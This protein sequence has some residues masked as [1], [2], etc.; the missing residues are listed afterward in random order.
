MKKEYK[1]IFNEI[2]PDDELLEGVFESAEKRINRHIPK[3]IIACTMCLAV[4]VAGCFAYNNFNS[5]SQ[6]DTTDNKTMNSNTFSNTIVAYASDD[7]PP[8]LLKADVETKL[9]YQ[10]VIT[11]IR[12]MSDDEVE[13][14]ISKHLEKIRSGDTNNI[15][16]QLSLT[17]SCLSLD[18]AIVN[19][20]TGDFFD[21][22]IE[23]PDEVESITVSN[24]SDY[25]LAEIVSK[26]WLY[27]ENNTMKDRDEMSSEEREEFSEKIFIRGHK[28]TLDGERYARDKAIEKEGEK[29]FEI[30]WEMAQP[31]YDAINEN[32]DMDLS[33]IRDVMT[34]TVEYKDA[35]SESA[36][37]QITFDSEGYMHAVLL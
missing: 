3:K 4:I 37:I 27:D 10:I 5:P 24:Q 2:R 19:E 36:D 20:Y 15:H 18:N 14:I 17:H 13:N 11:D 28:V 35:T 7:T 21:I 25:G 6:N 32:P 16:F 31:F 23:N 22:H 34:F 9:Q 26:D 8:T 1:E 33:A 29:C 30:H 12:N